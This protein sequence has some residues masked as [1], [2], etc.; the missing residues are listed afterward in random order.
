MSGS[1]ATARILSREP[2]FSPLHLHHSSSR[3]FLFMQ[4]RLRSPWPFTPPQFSGQ[5]SLPEVMDSFA[6]VYDDVM[7]SMRQ[8]RCGVLA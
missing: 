4:K 8:M 2:S 7:Q 1:G 3:A 6:S 5:G